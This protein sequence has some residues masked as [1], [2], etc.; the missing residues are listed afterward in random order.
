MRIAVFGDEELDHVLHQHPG[1]RLV[2]V[3]QVV[4]RDF[5]EVATKPGVGLACIRMDAVDDD[6]LAVAHQF[7]LLTGVAIRRHE[8]DRNLVKRLGSLERN[9]ALRCA[10]DAD[11]NLSAVA[12]ALAD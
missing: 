10:P 2:E 11:K 7:N 6:L 8:V 5:S 4:A 9:C 3:R 12:V 1:F